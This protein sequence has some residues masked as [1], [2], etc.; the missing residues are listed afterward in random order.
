MDQVKFALKIKEA[1][2]EKGWTQKELAERLKI[3]DKAVSK[4]ERVEP[5]PFNGELFGVADSIQ[6]LD[7]QVGFVLMSGASESHSRL[8]RT[9]DGAVSFSI[10]ELPTE[11]VEVEVPDLAE[12]D[13]V[14][15]PYIEGDVLKL[16]LSLE[17]Y[18]CCRL[19]FESAD[20]G[21]T[22]YYTGVSEDYDIMY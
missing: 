10:V 4:W 22:W 19:Y 5:D 17:K 13:Y 20:N 1:R 6:F 21:E 18:D 7:E 12:Y 8:Y 16:S 11:L 3:T 2:K 14:T 15:M 9:I